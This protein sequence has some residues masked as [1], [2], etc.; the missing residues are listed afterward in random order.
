MGGWEGRGSRQQDG[1][2]G[3]RIDGYLLPCALTISLNF[4]PTTRFCSGAGHPHIR[5]APLPPE[6]PQSH[7]LLHRPR[8]ELLLH[9]AHHVLH[10]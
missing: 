6:N 2:F 10:M 8:H 7:F 4:N 1:P 3:G 5:P 9:H